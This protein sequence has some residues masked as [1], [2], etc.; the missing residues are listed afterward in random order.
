ML[1]FV[2]MKDTLNIT[3]IQASLFWEDVNENLSHFEQL[4]DKISATDIILLPEMFNTSFCPKSNHL[5]EAMDG[6]TV[7]W[8]KEISKNR[9]CTI[10]GTLM[11]KEGDKV[12]NR[13][14]WISKNGSMYTYDKHHLFSLIKISSNKFVCFID[15]LPSLA[16]SKEPAKIPALPVRLKLLDLDKFSGSKS[17]IFFQSPNLPK[18]SL[19]LF[20]P[21][22]V[23]KTG[24]R[25][26]FIF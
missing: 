23:V 19:I 2:E 10:T 9:G 14:V 18:N 22:S 6:K 17:L 16:S 4:I 20:I 15:I 5:A 24:S 25:G 12:F 21:S 11:V 26:I 8:M 7:S 1:I 13:L 3:L